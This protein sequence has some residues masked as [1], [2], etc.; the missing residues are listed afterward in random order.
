MR[1][2]FYASDGGFKEELICTIDSSVIPEKG[3][4]VKLNNKNFHVIKRNFY[5]HNKI[6]LVEIYLFKKH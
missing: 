5:I 4:S 1:I 2:D 6:Y 3:D